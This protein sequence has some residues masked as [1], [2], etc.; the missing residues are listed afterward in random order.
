MKPTDTSVLCADLNNEAGRAWRC[1]LDPALHGHVDEE[2]QQIQDLLC[3]VGVRSVVLISLLEV[4]KF[5]ER[6]TIILCITHAHFTITLKAILAHTH[7][8]TLRQA[9]LAIV[10]FADNFSNGAIIIYVADGDNQFTYWHRY[11]C[12]TH[13]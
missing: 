9:T 10:L 2:L 7:V 12:C 3:L 11:K 4:L 6:A 5:Y 1:L 13:L 8:R